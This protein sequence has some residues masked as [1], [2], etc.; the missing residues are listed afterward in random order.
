MYYLAV[1]TRF[2]KR[3]DLVGAIAMMLIDDHVVGCPKKNMM[4][5]DAKSSG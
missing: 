3:S 2:P 5:V 4:V 1:M